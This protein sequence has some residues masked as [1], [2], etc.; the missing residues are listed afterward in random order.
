MGEFFSGELIFLRD[1]EVAYILLIGL[2][3]GYMT[4]ERLAGEARGGYS[5]MTR[6]RTSVRDDSS[7][8]VTLSVGWRDCTK[9]QRPSG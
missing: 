4:G 7:N 8:G 3:R 2:D 9:L 1:M 6:L 5:R